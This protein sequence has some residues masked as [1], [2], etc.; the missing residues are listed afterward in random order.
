MNC[1]KNE[2]LCTNVVS[3][4]KNLLLIL[5]IIV[6]P[7]HFY[8]YANT[9]K[10]SRGAVWYQIFP[11]R[12]C[13]GEPT[14][15]PIRQS[16]E[17]HDHVLE[18][19][20]P[21][22]WGSDWYS[23]SPW[24]KQRSADFYE[25]V[26]TRR[27]GGDLQ[28]MIHRLPYL[29]DLGVE[30][31][32]LNPIF[33]SP[34]LHKYDASSY[35]HVDPYFG[36][37]PKGDLDMIRSESKDES[38]WIWTKADL[39]FLKLVKEV[40]RLDMKIIIDGVWNHTGVN[41]WAFQDLKKNQRASAYK[42]WYVVD[43]FAD[44]QT[45]QVFRY[46]GWWGYEGLPIFK[47]TPDGENLHPEVKA[48]IFTVTSRWMDP[49]HD[50]DPS[51]GIDGW[52]LDVA[53]EVPI[54]FW[55]EWNKHVRQINSDAYTVA[56]NWH[57]SSDFVHQGGFSS[58]MNYHGFAHI[59]K[60]YAV[61][62]TLSS[63]QYWRELQQRRQGY[64]PEERLSLFN[65]I[66]SHDTPRMV[67]TIFNSTHQPQYLH[68]PSFDYDNSEL[69][70]ARQRKTYHTTKPNAMAWQRMKLVAMLQ[71]FD[72]GSPCLYYGAEAGLWGGDDPDNRKP[73]LWPDL[74][75]EHETARP[76]HDSMSHHE[77]AFDPK[78]HQF[79]RKLIHLRGHYPPLK[80]GTIQIKYSQE[81]HGAMGLVRSD[82]EQTLV[83]WVNPC[84][85]S[86]DIELDPKSL[87]QNL[88]SN[89]PVF[90]DHSHGKLTLP[91]YSA[92]MT[93]EK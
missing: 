37:D 59:L 50:G 5:Y 6:I 20:K 87:F 23:L 36:P 68:P 27:Y 92:L 19:W 53:D 4:M 88:I 14:N 32:Y 86:K 85:T 45:N 42:D 48:Y 57:E 46:Q 72:Q 67:S 54:K 8:L 89:G 47:D 61:D 80:H 12:F 84:S 9:S 35:H 49:N 10:W 25:N 22:P 7:H 18:N 26:F 28:G 41:F 79:Y 69:V 64:S 78:L 30:A 58:V 83:L 73:M 44:P 71:F 13:N 40:H 15:D 1:E 16:L 21:T 74:N 62:N 82:S 24:E 29:K 76:R 81:D 31:L 70:S 34:S 77:V 65:I 51:D 43:Q 60:A 38:K 93:L 90:P 3:H 55:N 33:Y 17:H 91:P 66:E 63:S 75:Y 11:E 2:T 56:E 52:R 39:L